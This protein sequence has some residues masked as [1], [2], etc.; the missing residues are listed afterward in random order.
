M[1]P[2]SFRLLKNILYTSPVYLY[3]LTIVSIAAAQTVPHK[4]D[5]RFNSQKMSDFHVMVVVD[6]D[7]KRYEWKKNHEKIFN[8]AL[9]EVLNQKGYGVESIEDMSY[10]KSRKTLGS[11]RRFPFQDE[12]YSQWLTTLDLKKSISAVLVTYIQFQHYYGGI[13][14]DWL[15]EVSIE[16]C[17]VSTTS[18]TKLLCSDQLTFINT[19]KVES[20]YGGKTPGIYGRTG[21]NPF[22]LIP[23][24]DT[25]SFI[26]ESLHEVFKN[27]PSTE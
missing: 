21:K 1:K 26:R 4:P 23:K 15:S 25:P 14:V 3:A 13:K 16:Y 17:L 9:T 20:T 6:P 19:E 8:S 7:S 2:R 10:I 22:R 11:T 27:L 12:N 5:E 18:G 24:K